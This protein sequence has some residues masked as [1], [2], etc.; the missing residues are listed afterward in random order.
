LKY[1]LVEQRVLIKDTE[2]QKL[3]VDRKSDSGDIEFSISD[4]F[5]MILDWFARSETDEYLDGVIAAL[6]HLYRVGK[7]SYKVEPRERGYTFLGNLLPE[8]TAV[9]SDEGDFGQTSID[10]FVT[11]AAESILMKQSDISE[12]REAM[13]VI[14][15]KGYLKSV[16]FI[17]RNS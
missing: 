3:L 10:D 14:K 17:H 16:N 8:N 13:H 9:S 4:L 11:Q 15:L 7:L 1:C 6:T 12:A 5:G 2:L